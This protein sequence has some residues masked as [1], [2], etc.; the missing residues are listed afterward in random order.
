M[1]IPKIIHETY[2]NYNLPFNGYDN[3]IKSTGPLFVCLFLI[4]IIAI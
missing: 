2:K 1:T 4:C 3:V